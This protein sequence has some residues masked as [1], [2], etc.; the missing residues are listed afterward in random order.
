MA[1]ESRTTSP[2]GLDLITRWEGLKL[3]LYYC[4]AGKPTIGVGHVVVPGEN[5][6]KITREQAMEILAKDVARFERALRKHTT[7]ELNSNQFDALVCF[8]FNVGEGGIIGTGVQAA[9]NTQ[10]FQDVPA[11]LAKW[12]RVNGK[13][14]P[15]LINRR[16]SEG[17]L[18]VRPVEEPAPPALAEGLTDAERA[19]VEASIAMSIRMSVDDYYDELR[20]GAEADNVA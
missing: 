7:V 9:V 2:V 5:L 17:E 12:N 13:P 14:H 11:A 6:T 15:G 3:D 10:R 1:N 8:L 16:K 4:P 18:F 20:R 19:E